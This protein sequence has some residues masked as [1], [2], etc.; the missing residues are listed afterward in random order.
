MSE[1]L[2][3]KTCTPCQGGIPPMPEKQARVMLDDVP[4][5]SL[6]DDAAWL[7]RHFDFKD[8]AGALAF[9]NRIGELAEGEGHHPDICLGYGYVDVTMQ[10]H[11]IG[12]LHDNDFILAAK[13]GQ[14][15]EKA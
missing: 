9:V 12:G 11:K 4:G 1:D 15:Y 3:Q 13:I 8:F 6:T 10:T 5:W 2:T 7:K 14:A